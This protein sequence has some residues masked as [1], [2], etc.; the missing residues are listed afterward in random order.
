MLESNH[1][2]WFMREPQAHKFLA[3][4]RQVPLQRLLS[5]PDRGW[6]AVGQSM[7]APAARWQFTGHLK[8]APCLK[9]NILE[10]WGVLTTNMWLK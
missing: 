8:A 5:S 2:Q 6:P 10:A 4:R 7:L 3:R 9:N 1:A